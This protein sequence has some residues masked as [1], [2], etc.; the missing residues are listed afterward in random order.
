MEQSLLPL[1]TDPDRLL[2]QDELCKLFGKSPSWAER[3]RWARTGPRY[4][5][6]GRTV[7][8]RARDILAY[9]EARAVETSD[10]GKQVSPLPTS[11]SVLRERMTSEECL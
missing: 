2:S 6:I 7:F 9:V 5:K 10:D 1:Q 3:H 8:Y 11:Y 4:H